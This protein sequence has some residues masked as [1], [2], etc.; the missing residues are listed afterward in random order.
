M[1]TEPVSV[2]APQASQAWKNGKDRYPVGGLVRMPGGKV[3]RIMPN[4][5][6]QRVKE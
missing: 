4:G 1:E 6:W 3:Y 2:K 5:S